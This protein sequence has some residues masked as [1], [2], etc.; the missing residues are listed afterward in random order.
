[1]DK[2][3]KLVKLGAAAGADGKE[4]RRQ[5][6]YNSLQHTNTILKMQ[7]NFETIKFSFEKIQI[8]LQPTIYNVQEKKKIKANSLQRPTLK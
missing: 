4:L 3:T 7:I 1:M 5:M 8:N 2:L 6:A